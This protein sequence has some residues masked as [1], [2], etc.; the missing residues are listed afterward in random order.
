MIKISD[1][2]IIQ[3]DSDGYGSAEFCGTIPESIGVDANTLVFARAVR[4]DDSLMVIPWHECALSENKRDWSTVLKLP[5]GGLYRAEACIAAPGA[6]LEWC[7]KI[8]CCYHIGVGDI[9]ITTGQSNMTG[10]GRD[11]AYD[12]PELGVHCFSRNGKWDI[13]TH[14]LGDSIDSI[15]DAPEGG[16]G[17]SPALS[18]ARMLKKR[19]GIPIGIIP[20]AVGGSPLRSWNIAEDGNL[21]D[22]MLKMLAY[23]GD[24]AGFIWFQ[25]CSDAYEES[26]STYFD[27]FASMVR[28]WREKLG[29]KPVV[30]VQLNRWVGE[31]NGHSDRYWGIVRD[32]QRRAGLELDGVYTVPSIDLPVTDGIHD[33]SGA[34]V[35]IGERLA[36]AALK[37]VYGKAG[38]TAPAV[39]GAEYIDSTHIKVFI[40]PCI[41]AYTMDNFAFG[42]DIE[43]ESGIIPC[44]TAYTADGGL[45][46]AS[47]REFSLPAK[48]HYAWRTQP[49][50]FAAR[51][52]HGL[53]LLACYGVEILRKTDANE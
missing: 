17:T 35:I 36:D 42:M 50:V 28:L 34:N 39:T 31:N 46:V 20:A 24:F 6:A 26:A 8:K 27:R 30:T 25:G 12:P 48:F 43:D 38:Q 14:P 13:A 7:G 23:T 40:S 10:Y 21:T 16:T 2:Q 33:S 52:M 32:A 37:C 22:N 51:D 47:S 1:F 4:E 18:F 49:P 9:W 41:Q 3:R 45:T 19:L 5:E 44:T 15:F 11:T 29:Y 53:P